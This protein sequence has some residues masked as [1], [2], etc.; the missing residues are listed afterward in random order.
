MSNKNRMNRN[1]WPNHTAIFL[2]ALV[3]YTILV[4]NHCVSTKFLIQIHWQ[5]ISCVS[6]LQFT[7][8]QLPWKWA[9]NHVLPLQKEMRW[10]TKLKIITLSEQSKS[11]WNFRP[12]LR[13][14]IVRAV[15]VFKHLRCSFSSEFNSFSLRWWN[16]FKFYRNRTQWRECVWVKDIQN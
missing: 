14:K 2:A 13:W 1:Q 10:R 15:F 16:L 6:K 11:Q 7:L 12:S 9:K 5:K 8:R 3:L 4:G